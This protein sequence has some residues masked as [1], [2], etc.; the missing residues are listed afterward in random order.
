[1]AAGRKGDVRVVTLNLWQR[2]GSWADRRSVVINGLRASNPML[3]HF[4]R[5]E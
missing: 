5:T 4:T 2:Y 3:Q 1:M